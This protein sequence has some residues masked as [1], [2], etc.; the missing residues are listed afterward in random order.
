MDDRRRARGTLEQE[1]LAV[2]AAA[3]EPLTSAQ[4]R[5]ELGDDLAYTTVMTVL[6][7]LYDKGEVTRARSGRAFAYGAVQ[8]GAELTARKMGRLLDADDDRAAVLT[9][10]V[11]VL[12]AADEALLVDLLQRAESAGTPGP[13]T[14]DHRGG[15][16]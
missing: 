4:V 2:L 1:V 7:R 15:P 3:G 12:S 11:S 6:G 10:F 16:R 5:E 13:S 8:D 14:E 9:R